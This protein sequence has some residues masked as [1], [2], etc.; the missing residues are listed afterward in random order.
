MNN[1]N[2]FYY[3]LTKYTGMKHSILTSVVL[4]EVN[5]VLLITI[6]QHFHDY[7]KL[8]LWTMLNNKVEKLPVAPVS[9]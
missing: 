1:S 2:N 8:C 7:L 4:D 5:N 6:A 3:N 9:V